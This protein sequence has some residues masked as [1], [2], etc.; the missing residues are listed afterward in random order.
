MIVYKLT[1]HDMR[2]YDGFQWELGKWVETSGKGDLCG[3]GWLH[4]YEHPLLA[5]L[6]SPAHVNFVKKRLFIAW[7]GRGEIKRDGQIKIGSTKMKLVEEIPLPAISTIQK[8]AYGILCA[9]EVYDDTSFVEWANKWLIGKDRSMDSAVAASNAAAAAANSFSAA[10]YYSADA[11]YAN[12]HSIA[13]STDEASSDAAYA[14]V[15]TNASLT[16]KKRKHP[17]MIKLA[18]KAMLVR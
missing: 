11:V 13:Y 6:H 15:Y 4:A 9:L 1:D 5:V 12:Y 2:T 18:E 14:A 17:N 7:T 3:P 10:A 8:I 16:K